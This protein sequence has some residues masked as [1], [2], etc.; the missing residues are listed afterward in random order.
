MAGR[1]VWYT[2]TFGDLSMSDKPKKL[3][4][5]TGLDD[6][7]RLRQYINNLDRD[8]FNITQ[9]L[10]RSPRLFEQSAEPTIQRN[11]AAYWRDTDD[12]KIYNIVNISGNQKKVELT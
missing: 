10:D 1:W 9:Y 5:F 3:S 2:S 6:A 7:K 8:V 11:T 4:N 12:G